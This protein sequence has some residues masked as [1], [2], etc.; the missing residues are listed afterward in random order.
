MDEEI[1]FL[2]QESKIYPLSKM[3]LGIPENDQILENF[4]KD[5]QICDWAFHKIKFFDCIL[6]SISA[7]FDS[8]TEILLEDNSSVL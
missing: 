7:T 2:Y 6:T 4:L 5:F 3:I 1:L 8:A